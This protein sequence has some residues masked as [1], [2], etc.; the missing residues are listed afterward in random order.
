M[1]MCVYIFIYTY[2]YIWPRKLSPNARKFALNE[3]SIVKISL[4]L[5]P[6]ESARFV[7]A[8]AAAGET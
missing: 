3:E 5:G 2:R 4:N 6:H 8:A 1:C 7:A